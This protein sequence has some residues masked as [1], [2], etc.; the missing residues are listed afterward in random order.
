MTSSPHTEPV[1]VEG[2]N[3]PTPEGTSSLRPVGSDGST[4]GKLVD[5]IIP[6]AD[7]V[8]VA[9][10]PVLFVAIPWLLFALMLSGPFAVLVALTVLL[11]VA[12]VLFAA[13]VAIIATPYVVV[14]RVYHR[15]RAAHVSRIPGAHLPP[16]ERPR[17]VATIAAR[18]SAT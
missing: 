17:L 8:V 5:E 13:V 4:F 11:A 16:L 12:A 18:N 1:L 10:P 14:R 6:L 7:V 3:T 2:Q 15:Y 9:G